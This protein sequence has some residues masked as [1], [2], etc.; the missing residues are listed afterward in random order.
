MAIQRHNGSAW[1]AAR[2]TYALYEPNVSG[3]GPPIW[4][5][6]RTI[7]R[8]TGGGWQPASAGY[9][10]Y[11]D[12]TLSAATLTQT[13]NGS[14]EILDPAT[15]NPN[16]YSESYVDVTAG[17]TCYSYALWWRY[18]AS[19]EDGRWHFKHSANINPGDTRR[20]AM[21]NGFNGHH[22]VQWCATAFVGQITDHL[23]IP[24]G[25]QGYSRFAL[26]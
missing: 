26:G 10:A 9:A 15:A 14:F 18:D 23:S 7:W 6:A 17:W 25:Q 11:A 8:V 21:V 5:R 22:R 2:A 16:A 24:P 19:G 13:H 3:G 20:V 4:L 1:G 12:V